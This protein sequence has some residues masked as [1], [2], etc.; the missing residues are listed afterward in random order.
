MLSFASGV[1][2]SLDPLGSRA[3]GG[4]DGSYLVGTVRDGKRAAAGLGEVPCQSQQPD[5]VAIAANVGSWDW[6]ISTNQ[7]A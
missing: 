4:V 2:Q 6:T 3:P 5:A 7:L 1:P